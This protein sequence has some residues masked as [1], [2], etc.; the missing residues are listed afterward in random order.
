MDG[1]NVLSLVLAGL[2]AGASTAA[3]PT[4]P[5]AVNP[6]APDAPIV[7]RRDTSGKVTIELAEPGVAV[8]KTFDGTSVVT[9]LVAGK[10]QVAITLGSDKLSISAGGTRWSASLAELHTLETAVG[11]LRAS[12]AVDAGR[13]LLERTILRPD[14]IEGNAMLL[15]RALLGTILGDGTSTQEYQ[16]W[17]MT[18]TQGARIERAQKHEHGPGECWDEYSIEAIRIA[19]NYI[20]CA[21]L[22][23]WKGWWCMAGCGLIYNIRAEGAFMWFMKC[24]GG[25]YLH[26]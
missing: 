22:C 21:Q 10:E 20:D 2:L 1:R 4:P 5:R 25:F 14:S 18:R 15:T 3:A 8:R 9:T 19:S 12:K 11:A 17:A 7:M 24:N 6:A 26:G 23:H 13:R 16:R